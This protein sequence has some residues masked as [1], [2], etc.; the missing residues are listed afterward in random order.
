MV[1]K[2]VSKNA[3]HKNLS[4]TVTMGRISINWQIRLFVCSAII[5]SM[6]LICSLH[7]YFR[8][9]LV[10]DSHSAFISNCSGSTE[11]PRN[12]NEFNES[13]LSLP[14][15]CY[16]CQTPGKLRCWQCLMNRIKSQSSQETRPIAANGWNDISF[17]A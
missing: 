16:L 14:A 6:Q 3:S 9:I 8:R 4:T 17:F 1:F 11:T 13:K 15:C 12:A 2:P 7:Q 5:E 10:K